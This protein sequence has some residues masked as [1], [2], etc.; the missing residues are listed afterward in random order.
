M[1]IRKIAG[2]AICHKG[3]IREKN[4]DNLLFINKNLPMEH[5]GSKD[6]LFQEEI[7]SEKGALFGVFDGMGGY[8]NGEEASFIASELVKKTFEQVKLSEEVALEILKESCYD[9]NEKICALMEEKNLKMGT[10]VSLLLFLKEKLYLCNIGD[11]PIYRL[12]KGELI[13]IFKEHTQKIYFK[14]F[15]DIDE[16]ENRK[17]PLT[18][19]IGIPPTEFKISPFLDQLDYQQGDMYLICSDGLSD[20]VKKKEMITYLEKTIPSEEKIMQLLDAA[21][22]NGGRDNITIILLEIL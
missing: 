16:L 4:E 12:R 19:C 5:E 7:D 2:V 3:K 8:F 9:A 15:G 1:E 14:N 18:Q 21:L 10:T 22:R 13:P 17:F 11:S 20:M 6:I